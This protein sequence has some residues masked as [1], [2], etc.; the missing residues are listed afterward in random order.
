MVLSPNQAM[1]R[2]P[3]QLSLPAP[4]TWGGAPVLGASQRPA[5]GPACRTG[6]VLHTSLSTPYTCDRDR[7]L[8]VSRMVRRLARSARGGRDRPTAGGGRPDLA[9]ARRVAAVRAAQPGR[10]AE[11]VR[12]RYKSPQVP[13]KGRLSAEGTSPSTA[14]AVETPRRLKRTHY[15]ARAPLLHLGRRCSGLIQWSGTTSSSS[16][17]RSPSPG[18]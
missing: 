5:A 1:V 16:A 13:P 10:A 15:G 8:L 12:R 18:G 14:A 2:R 17:R 4:R 6:R 9:R 3:V 7:S 11:V